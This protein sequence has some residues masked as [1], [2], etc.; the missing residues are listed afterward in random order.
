MI[1][2]D[3]VLVLYILFCIIVSVFV[4]DEIYS[5]FYKLLILII[6]ILGGVLVWLIPNPVI[7]K[8]KKAM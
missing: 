4:S 5:I 3:P 2:N 8:R 7:I 6:L 1:K